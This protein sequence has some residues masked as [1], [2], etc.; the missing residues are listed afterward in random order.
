[1]KVCDMCGKELTTKTECSCVFGTVLLVDTTYHLCPFC[2]DKVEKF[3]K[4]QSFRNSK[5]NDY[6]SKTVR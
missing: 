3:I 2:K 5:E 4:F 1:M 6:G